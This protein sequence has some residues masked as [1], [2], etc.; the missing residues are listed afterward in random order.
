MAVEGVAVQ[1]T[2][3]TLLERARDRQDADAWNRLHT[4]YT[5]LLAAWL[6]SRGLQAADVDDL[7]QHAL[8]IVAEKLPAFQHAGRT[9]SFR[10][11]LRGI[12]ANVMR[13]FARRRTEAGLDGWAERLED[14][15]S[16][17]ARLWDADH[18]AHVLRQLL[19][20]AAPEF[21]AAAWTAFR[22]TALEERPAATVAIELGMSVNA[23]LLA[24][25]R[26]L[27]HLRRQARGWVDL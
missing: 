12:L 11:W 6:R 19:A 13:A 4:L 22:L 7:S 24:R 2:S 1:S 16:E 26:V 21:S 9:G 27:S 10:A 23:V 3:L 15:T 18:D 25:S 8:A 20:T 14:D 17:L 5:P